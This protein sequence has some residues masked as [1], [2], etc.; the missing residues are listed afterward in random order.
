M[1]I[2]IIILCIIIYSIFSS[3]ILAG[4]FRDNFD[5]GNL[6]GWRMTKFDWSAFAEVE[7]VS[8]WQIKNGMAVS[9]DND[10]A[11]IHGLFIDEKIYGSW[12]DYTAEVSVKLAKPLRDCS[13]WSGVYLSVRVQP[14]MPMSYN[15]AI[16]K[17]GQ[18]GEVA[19]GYICLDKGDKG[20]D[21]KLPLKTESNRWYRLKVSVEGDSI[22]CFVDEKEVIA[23]KGNN[24]YNIG[25]T[26]FAVNGLE[27]YFDDFTATG[28][29]V[30]DG[31]PG[32]SINP[33]D[34]QATLW[35]RLKRIIH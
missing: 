27:A 35:G 24:L 8:N 13:E 11:M 32:F 4:T 5:D 21:P 26:G 23:Y 12:K 16:R 9:G 15:L 20:I 34:K 10:V 18:E 31:G 28:P 19:C 30:P 29:D 14:R 25:S 17:W 2:W 1:K 7:G 3:V 22:R 6:N 33:R